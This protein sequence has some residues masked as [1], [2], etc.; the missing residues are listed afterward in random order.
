VEG[1]VAKPL[2]SAYKSG[3]IWAKVRHA[4]TVD[5]AVVGFTGSAR[6][7]KALTVRLPNGYLA[8]SQRLTTALAAVIAPRLVPRSGRSVT[9]AADSY[10]PTGGDILGG[11]GR[12]NPARGRHRDAA[13]PTSGTASA[14]A[15][16]ELMVWHR[17]R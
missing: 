6:N 14:G 3:R 10:T 2:R 15:M 1:I 16:G 4:D 5:A 13:A 8:L 12:H 7:P 11:H 17:S 9:K